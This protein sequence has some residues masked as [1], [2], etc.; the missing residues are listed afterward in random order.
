[1]PESKDEFVTTLLFPDEYAHHFNQVSG[2]TTLSIVYLKRKF[3]SKAG[4]ELVNYPVA[5]CLG[6]S[7]QDER[8]VSSIVFGVL[9]VSLL[10][11]I[12]FMVFTYWD[13]LTPGTRIPIGLLM[14]AALYGFRWIFA[15]R[16]HRLIFDMRDGSRLMWK[17]RA[18]DYKYKHASAAK[19]AELAKS[20]GILRDPA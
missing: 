15:A 17:S 5:D 13:S 16:R 18:G 20:L 7:Y 3:L 11:F 10:S 2:L 1:M 9:L 12:A 14:L 19:V 8:P 4:Y 6:I